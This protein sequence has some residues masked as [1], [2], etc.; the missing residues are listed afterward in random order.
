M[1]HTFDTVYART[2]WLSLD[3]C[4]DLAGIQLKRHRFWRRLRRKYSLQCLQS[5]LNIAMMEHL[6]GH[7]SISIIIFPFAAMFGCTLPIRWPI[8][9][10]AGQGRWR[11]IDLQGFGLK[12]IESH[13]GN[14][15]VE[16]SHPDTA[17][18]HFINRSRPSLL[19][20]SSS[21]DASNYMQEREISIAWLCLLPVFAGKRVAPGERNKAQRSWFWQK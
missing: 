13:T 2:F 1:T 17:S 6:G 19:L 20:P 3:D 15:A 16:G 12:P 14:I 5:W 9:Q 4:E 7:F 21:P 10:F 18:L 8:A 11:R